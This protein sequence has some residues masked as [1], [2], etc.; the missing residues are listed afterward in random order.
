M[1]DE[2][3]QAESLNVQEPASESSESVEMPKEET[4][5]NVE[6][7]QEKTAHSGDN[8]DNLD[9]ESESQ[10]ES[11]EGKPT[12]EEKRF[13][14]KQLATQVKNIS[15][16]QSAIAYQKGYE[17]AIK[18]IEAQY[19]FSSKGIDEEKRKEFESQLAYAQLI[20]LKQQ[21][22]ALEA[23][24]AETLKNKINEY[25]DKNIENVRKIAGSINFESLHQKCPELLMTLSEL[26]N[27]TEI[28]NEMVDNPRKLSDLINLSGQP[29]LLKSELSKISSSIKRNQVVSSKKV[30]SEPSDKIKPNINGIGSGGDSVSD[31][32]AWI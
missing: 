6:S 22:E 2:L 26:D 7:E 19:G 3:I 16:K 29:A 28:L 10:K 4:E 18:K 1:S 11:E 15:E 12:K 14:Q 5:D 13:T 21:K 20:T 9:K 8:D 24:A 25:A 27:P 31:I 17:E 23:K 30:T 32:M